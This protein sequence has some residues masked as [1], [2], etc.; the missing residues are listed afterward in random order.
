MLSDD[1]LSGKY[2]GVEIVVAEKVGAFPISDTGG[3]AGVRLHDDEVP[4][5]TSPAFLQANPIGD[6][7]NNTEWAFPLAEC[8]HIVFFAMAIG[9]IVMVDLRLL[10][11]AFQ[12]RT[13]AEMVRDT[14]VYTLVGLAVTIL[15]G[16]ALFVSDPRMYS[17]NA[18]FRL[19]AAILLVAILYN[20]TVHSR[21]ATRGSSKAVVAV[22]GAISVLL[23]VSVVAGGVFVGLI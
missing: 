14:W 21:V 19:K 12:R 22:V 11:L 1:G 8:F 9:S 23:W 18:W 13:P 3:D 15:A 10:G 17:F 7:L 20:Y 5:V 2:S 6:V 4:N 16:M